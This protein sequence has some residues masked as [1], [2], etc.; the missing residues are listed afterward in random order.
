MP[1]RTFVDEFKDRVAKIESDAVA[2][3]LNL[4][5]ICKEAGISRATPDRWRKKTPKTVLLI[6]KMEAIIERRREELAKEEAAKPH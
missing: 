4:T 3:G 5:V 6:K 2:V 1:K